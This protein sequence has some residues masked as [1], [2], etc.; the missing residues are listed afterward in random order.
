MLTPQVYREDAVQKRP[1]TALHSPYE[2]LISPALPLCLH[3]AG[4]L[5]SQPARG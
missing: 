5:A 4:E 1:P 2:A 3:V